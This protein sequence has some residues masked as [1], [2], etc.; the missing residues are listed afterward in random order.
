MT[1]TLRKKVL[2]ARLAVKQAA[3]GPEGGMDRRE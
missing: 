1:K 2:A 3:S